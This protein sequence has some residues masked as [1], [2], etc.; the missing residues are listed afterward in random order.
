VINNCRYGAWVECECDH[1]SDQD[2]VVTLASIEAGTWLRLWN[3]VDRWGDGSIQVCVEVGAEGLRAAMH[4][5]TLKIGGDS[6]T[7]FLQDLAQ[8]FR[9]W[10]G[11]LNWRSLEPRTGDRRDVRIRRPCRVVL[12]GGDAAA[13][14]DFLAGDGLDTRRGRRAD[15]PVRRRG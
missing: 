11:T 13:A 10:E 15:A 12:H 1:R 5:V 6:L 8:R 14:P 9:G 3:C 2:Q 7:P 4:A